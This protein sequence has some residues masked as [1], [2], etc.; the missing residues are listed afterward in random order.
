MAGLVLTQLFPSSNEKEKDK[1]LCFK[2]V[3]NL[4]KAY[5]RVD[6]D[7]LVVLDAKGFASKIRPCENPLEDQILCGRFHWLY[8]EKISFGVRPAVVHFV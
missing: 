2:I 1:G 4:E 5:K 3:M 7:F 8:S 6:W